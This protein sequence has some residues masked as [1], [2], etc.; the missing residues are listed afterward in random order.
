MLR[1][2][3]KSFGS[4]AAFGFAISLSITGALSAQRYHMLWLMTLM[5][6]VFFFAR[7]PPSSY[8]DDFAGHFLHAGMLDL[9]AWVPER[10]AGYWLDLGAVSTKVCA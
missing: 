8:F 10:L 3:L 5:I 9:L 7:G 1:I 4:F 6:C 2:E